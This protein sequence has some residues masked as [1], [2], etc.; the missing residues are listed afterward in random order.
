[1]NRE[2]IYKEIK[3]RLVAVLFFAIVSLALMGLNTILKYELQGVV[4]VAVSGYIAGRSE[5]NFRNYL[6]QNK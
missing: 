2:K 5:E 4:I 6:K 3:C 1:M